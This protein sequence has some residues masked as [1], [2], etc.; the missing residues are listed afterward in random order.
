MDAQRSASY[1]D[2]HAGQRKRQS[3]ATRA[4]RSYTLS[5]DELSYVIPG[6]KGAE[7]KR[8]LTNVSGV[9]KP[10][11]VAC[12]MGT[13]GSGKTS[14]LNVLSG[15]HI[16]KG[17]LHG[18]VLVNG[19]PRNAKFRKLSAYVEQDDLL[20][21]YLTVAETLTFTA[22]LRLG[23]AYSVA[24]KQARAVEVMNKLGLV[25]C[26]DTLIG[27]AQMRGVSGGERKRTSIGVDLIVGPRILFLDEPTSGLDSYT[28]FHIMETVQKLA[29]EGCSILCAIH[30]PREKIF[31]LFDKCILLS[32]G[33]TSYY[34]P[35][36]EVGQF[37]GDMG[38]PCPADD[39]LA[40]FLLDMT[41]V[42]VRTTSLRASST[43]VGRRI[44][45]AFL[46]SPYAALARREIAA[47][48]AAGMP[49]EEAA[50]G[51]WNLPWTTEFRV[52][53]KRAFL[54]YSRNPRLA[55]ISVVQSIVQALI[56]GAVFFGTDDDQ[57]G[58]RDREG[59]LFFLTLSN[60]FAAMSIS[61]FVFQQ[62]KQVFARDRDSGAYR[63]SS[64]Y[65]SKTVAELP[66][67]LI[68]P[69]VYI[70]IVYPMVGLT[71][72][73]GR[74]FTAFITLE[75]VVMCATG[76]GL[77]ISAL[78]SSIEVA[79]IIGPISLLLL[80]LFGG[81]YVNV[82]NLWVGFKWIEIFSF[83][84][85]GYKTL[86]INEFEGTGPYACSVDAYCLRNGTLI[87]DQQGFEG[88]DKW[89]EF[90]KLWGVVV[91]FRLLAYLFLRFLNRTRPR[92]EL[93]AALPA[94]CVAEAEA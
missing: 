57:N 78:A 82:D 35:R 20:L 55:K 46:K 2:A 12:V 6:A 13:S 85:Y 84:Q 29:Q 41:T 36:A 43:D 44:R 61:M 23:R 17:S 56:A 27:N 63:C 72:D 66:I 81:F 3:I 90:G 45:G 62:E 10:G 65:L 30:Q 69:F 40:D 93:E 32:K 94:P 53:V 48:E 68:A 88:D 86:V 19:A 26:R 76:L 79:Q 38:L 25:D 4:M 15:R 60:S 5:W 80:M 58:I 39:N 24:E 73:W 91:L 8:V 34:G 67:Q 22:M 74:F 77:A 50:E 33:E 49:A 92:L 47:S 11:E 89:D 1:L 52:L 75:S 54:N 37:F 51:H 64:Y 87:L 31:N 9:V 7:K 42:D 14:L 28:A 18:A 71:A 83:I 16:A 59:A 70:C 21:P